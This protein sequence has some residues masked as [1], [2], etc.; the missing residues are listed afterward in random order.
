MIQSVQL[1][2]AE[3]LLLKIEEQRHKKVIQD[4]TDQLQAAVMAIYAAHGWVWGVTKGQMQRDP[5]DQSVVRFVYDDGTQAPA[6]D[7]PAESVPD[8]K[9]VPLQAS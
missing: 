6:V 1:S 2:A 4:S 7:V 9:I 5:L 8:L 3:S